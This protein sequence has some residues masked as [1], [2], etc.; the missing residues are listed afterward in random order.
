MNADIRTRLEK[1]IVDA[2]GPEDREFSFSGEDY[3]FLRAMLKERTGIELGPTKHNMVYARLAKR[4]RRLG[5]QS[6]RQ[7]IEFIGSDAGREELGAT[8][9][10]LT[11]NLTKF[12]RENHHFEHLAG[13]ALQEIRARAATGGR[14]LRIWSAGCS[15][16]EEPYSIA[17]TLL[18]AM[19]DI[20]QWDA[21]ILATDIDTEMVRRGAE[22]VYNASALEGIPH[23]I[24]S[25]YFEPHGPDKVRLCAEA[26]ALISFKYLNLIEPWPMKGPFDVIFCRNVV[27]YFDKDTQRTL[28]DRY[29]N[30]LAPG[31]FLYIGHSENLFGITER[32]KLLGRNIHR[33]IA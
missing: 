22:G 3:A 5:M 25:K 32:F 31:G 6:F 21:R 33:K 16:G 17:I 11:T 20:K 28:F 10:A 13:Q 8:L 19:P 26:R 23:E 12:F 15:S 14:R 2:P 7:Y 18:R 30:L 9:N 1:G 27:I 4:L 24:A 29:A